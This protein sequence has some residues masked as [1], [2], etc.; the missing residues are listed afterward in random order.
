[1]VI[2]TEV[3]GF[4]FGFIIGVIF[5]FILQLISP[6][7][8]V[9]IINNS[10]EATVFDYAA[11]INGSM[12][13][14]AYFLLAN[15]LIIF[16]SSFVSGVLSTNRKQVYCIA[17]G[18]IFVSFIAFNGELLDA[19]MRL[20]VSGLISGILAVIISLAILRIIKNSRSSIDPC[21]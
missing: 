10:N 19:N 1:M 2:F 11:V 3:K 17:C 8:E 4:F 5:S 9:Y 15:F 13:Y 7:V 18:A 12:L 16:F 20:Y 6:Y 14:S 21:C